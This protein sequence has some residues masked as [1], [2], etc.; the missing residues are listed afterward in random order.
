MS[1][2]PPKH[3]ADPVDKRPLT[4]VH[5][6]LAGPA[7]T[8]YP[9]ALGGWDLRPRGGGA[10]GD[11]PDDPN[12]SLQADIY[13]QRLGAMSDFDHPHNLMLVHQ[14]GLLEALPLKRGDRVLEIGG[15]RSGLLPWLERT[16][17]IVGTGLDISPVWVAAQNAAAR[18]RGSDTIWVLGDAEVLPF[19]D[20][21]FAAVVAF[22]V[23]EHLTHLDRALTEAFR[24]LAPG[25][26]LVVHMPV[27]D[28]DGSFDGFQ[29]SRDPGDYA[30]RQASVGHFHERMPTRRQ[31]R[32]RLEGAG[33]Q[34]LD[35]RSFNVWIQPLHDHRMLPWLGRMKNRR[36]DL[37]AGG[38][39]PHGG[40]AGRL[41]GRAASAPPL[42]GAGAASLAH[43]DSATPAAS[44]A[45]PPG[46][47]GATS[48]PPP[49]S[50]FTKLYARTVVPLAQALSAPDRLGSLLGIGGSC[51]F[52]AMK[53]G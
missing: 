53:P 24:V 18:A 11:A 12:K 37:G 50:R 28:I 41:R 46:A 17:G 33:F 26:R 10:P 8:V 3:L 7:G 43:A 13:D 22:D 6:G 15:H 27:R 31:M 49:T 29:R 9:E 45:T 36:G 21:A 20:G 39:P 19:A 38:Q 2:I 23:F 47:S 40:L 42:A 34:V 14:K 30:A 51:S 25:G 1:S 4:A 52:V 44:P 16:R 5:G 48:G 35:L 32:T